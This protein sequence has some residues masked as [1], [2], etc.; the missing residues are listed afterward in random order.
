[1]KIIS[2]H[3][4]SWDDE[5]NTSISMMVTFQ[6]LGE[7]IPFT[8]HSNDTERHGRELFCQASAGRF[9]TV[10]P[11]VSQVEKRNLPNID[12]AINEKKI[13]IFASRTERIASIRGVV[14][15]SLKGH[16]AKVFRLL[17]MAAIIKA[18]PQL[19]VSTMFDGRALP[20]TCEGAV[21]VVNEYVREQMRISQE[22]ECV[23]P[24]YSDLFLTLANARSV[25]DV[26]AISC[27]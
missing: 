22:I 9:G 24:H 8:A 5:L 27:K 16:E 19:Y 18:D 14:P 26:L 1:M 2:A 21:A 3:S 7:E 17:S 4:P 6:E 11:F 25:E 10:A 23:L 12:K 13:E 15:E 20:E